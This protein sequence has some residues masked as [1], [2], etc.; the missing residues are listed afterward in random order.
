MTV[1]EQAAE[2]ASGPIERALR[3]EPDVGERMMALARELFP[4]PR[5]LTGEG[6]RATLRAIGAWAPLDVTEV[7]SGTRIFDW[8]APL[9][10]TVREAWVRDAEGRLVVDAAESPLRLLG[11]GA[12]VEANVTGA[13]L[14]EHLYSLPEHPDWIP[15]RTSYYDRAWGFCV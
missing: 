5:S 3:A 1:A 11:Y 7:P 4:L 13:E 9:E 12:P 15:Y 14:L 8:T 10:W 6:V 2:T